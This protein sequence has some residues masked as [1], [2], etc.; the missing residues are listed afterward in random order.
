[1]TVL[2]EGPAGWAWTACNRSQGFGGRGRR[3]VEG[4]GRR[5][6]S[7]RRP[8]GGARSPHTEK[9]GPSGREADSDAP[10]GCR[11]EPGS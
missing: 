9:H 8:L 2:T 7:P 1:M 5:G 6:V 11:E 3:G 10:K 4:A